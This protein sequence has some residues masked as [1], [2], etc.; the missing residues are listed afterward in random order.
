MLKTYP[1]CVA[2]ASRSDGLEQAVW[3]DLLS[4]TAEEIRRIETVTGKTL[5][6]LG[7][8][9]EIQSSR[10]LRNDGGALYMST[11]SAAIH[12]REAQVTPPLGFVLSRERLVTVRFMPL[13]T[14][15]A[16]AHR[17]SVAADAPRTGI[18]TFVLLCQEIVDHVAD[19]LEQLSA[20]LTGLSGHAF[21]AE[22][23]RG[24]HP[25]RANRLLRVQMRKLGQLGDRLSEVR[26]G[27]QGLGRVV[28]FVEQNND[29]SLNGDMKTMLASLV[30]DI[31]SLAEYEEQL[32]NKVQFILD[33]LVG[34]IG[35]VQND[36]IKVLTIVSIAGIPPTLVAGIYG[37][38]FKFMPEYDWAWGYPYAWAVMILSAVVPLAW[39]KLKGWF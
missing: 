17:F 33:A 32:A 15:D 21:Q 24:R 3:I 28:A 38:N 29:G 31:H 20:A 10:R 34:L 13:A 16:V 35:I 11:P 19:M 4:P 25:A 9:S 6:S 23:T 39:F 22:D 8:L 26:D 37:M 2:G 5:P 14:F 27:I 36:I 18:E 1:A 30:K 7:S 12:P